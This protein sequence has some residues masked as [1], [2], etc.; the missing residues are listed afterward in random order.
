[1]KGNAIGREGPVADGVC[2]GSWVWVDDAIVG[3]ATDRV[4]IV[5]EAAAV[6]I[7]GE[8]FFEEGLVGGLVLAERAFFVVAGF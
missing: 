1:M 7:V 6:G 3:V 2:F 4:A 5:V 8:E